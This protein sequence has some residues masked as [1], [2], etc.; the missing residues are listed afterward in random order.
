[1]R[2]GLRDGWGKDPLG[3]FLHSGVKSEDNSD[4]K[5]KLRLGRK[6][7]NGPGHERVGVRRSHCT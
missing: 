4:S 1:M 6:R 3:Q 5:S 7:R 2:E